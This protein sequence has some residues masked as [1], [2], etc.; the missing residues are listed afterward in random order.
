MNHASDA[1]HYFVRA[2]SAA[3]R[4]L[5]P[6]VSIRA[7]AGDAL[8]LSVVTFDP[9]AEVPDHAHPHEQMGVMLA[10]RLEFTI[11]GRTEVLE[12]GDIWRIPSN[13]PHR[14][15]ALDGPAIA[16]DVFHPV[17]EDYRT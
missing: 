13:V 10:G 17:R 4:A 8:M 16:L 11:G 2:D 15:R 6:G 3:A 9:G 14:A 7:T 12:V 1:D 5:L